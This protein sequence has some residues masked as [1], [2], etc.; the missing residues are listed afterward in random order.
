MWPSNKLA[1][2][3]GFNLQAL[4]QTS[5]PRE[6]EC[7]RRSD[8]KRANNSSSSSSLTSVLLGTRDSTSRIIVCHK[9]KLERSCRKGLFLAWSDPQRKQR[10]IPQKVSTVGLGI[11][12]PISV[13]SVVTKQGSRQLLK[14]PELNTAATG[15]STLTPY[16]KCLNPGSECLEI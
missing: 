7:R 9:L 12:Q 11:P 3:P 1:T 2:C 10:R 4:G 5:I 16:V 14:P 15:R 6:P 8:R 13:L